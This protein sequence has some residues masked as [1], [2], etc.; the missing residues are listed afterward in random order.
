MKDLA[1]AYAHTLLKARANKDDQAFEV[2]FGKFIAYL[3]SRSHLDLLDDI[4]DRADRIQQAGRSEGVTVLVANEADIER[5]PALAAD[6]NELLSDGYRV[7]VDQNLVGGYQIR[8][9]TRF[10][11]A[12]YRT[13]LLDLYRRMINH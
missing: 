13:R 6:H 9:T 1:N 7:E 8:G 10:V 2:F 11:D 3:K 4:R 5:I 12:S